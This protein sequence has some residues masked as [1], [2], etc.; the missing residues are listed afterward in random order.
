[1]SDKLQTIQVTV[2][3][4]AKPQSESLLA[5]RSAIL[6]APELQSLFEQA[7]AEGWSTAQLADRLCTRLPEYLLEQDSLRLWE[8][9]L[10]LADEFTQLGGNMLLISSET[11]KAIAKVSPDD[12]Y[13][14]APVSR[15]TGGL[16]QPLPRLRPDLE[17][18]LVDWV[19]TKGREAKLVADLAKRVPQTEYLSEVGDPKL[20]R[21][22]R[23]GRAQIV[24]RLQDGL[25][26]LLQECT[27]TNKEFLSAFLFATEPP[28]DM[29][30]SSRYIGYAKV[31][32]TVADPM[33]F[34]LK[35]DPFT[36]L[37]NQ[38][39]GQWVRDIGRSVSCLAYGTGPVLDASVLDTLPNG[40][41]IAEPT[42]AMALRE[43]RVLAIPGAPTVMV[44][45]WMP[46]SV[47][48]IHPESFKCASREFLDRWEVA[49]SFEYTLFLNLNAL[50]AY[51]LKDVPAHEARA[52]V[53]A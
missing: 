19:F 11:G 5:A 17:G 34:N 25:P 10:Y 26:E 12:I 51:D 16:A 20:L 24:A 38:I 46:P 18:M 13:V 32:T 27:G 9:A 50:S 52:E 48:L 43:K 23:G 2:L 3:S 53:V 21:A 29:I 33:T 6:V 8:V 14:P 31:I 22:T 37:R 30:P 15:E 47:V 42:T 1:M 40:F 36:T 49:A 44:H 7:R 45:T 28:P 4:L 35:H 41:W 39:T